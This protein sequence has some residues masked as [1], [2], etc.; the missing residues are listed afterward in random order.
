MGLDKQMWDIPVIK[1]ICNKRNE[2]MISDTKSMNI[3][4]VTN[5]IESVI[6]FT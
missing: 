4:E 6:S 2:V 5:Y 1:Y 3:K